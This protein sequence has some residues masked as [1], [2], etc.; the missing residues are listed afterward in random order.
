MTAGDA[1]TL[2]LLQRWHG[3]D[4]AAL[5]ALIA[6]ELPWLRREVGHRI[7]DELRARAAPEDL[8]QQALVD[9]LQH[10]P[11]FSVDDEGHFRALLLRI[12]ENTIRKAIRDGRRQKRWAGREEPLPSGSVAALSVGSTRPASAADRNER[13]AWVQLALDLLDP[14]DREIVLRRQWEGHSHADIGRDLGIG[15]EAARKRFERALARLA[16]LV[17]RLRSG[18]VDAVL[19][20]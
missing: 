18:Q 5:D 11:R 1:P 4:R 20:G 15:E 13:R 16:Q 3:G 2:V 6:R 8:V 9:V 17:A 7:G 10:G 12:V 19:R 14:K